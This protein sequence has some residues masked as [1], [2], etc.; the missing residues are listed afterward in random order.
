MTDP[1]SPILADLHAAL[2]GVERDFGTAE[3]ARHVERLTLTAAIV[4]EALRTV[5]CRTLLVGGGAIEFYA[6]D[7]YLTRDVDL[8]VE[9]PS[10]APVRERLATI[11]DALG[12]AKLSGRHWERNGLLVEVPGHRIEDP[13]VEV[14]VGSYRL[15]VVR[16]EVVL[17]GRVV[18]FDQT[19]HTGHAAQAVL[20][21]RAAPEAL[22]RTLLRQLVRQERAERAFAAIEEL[23]S[24]G[25]VVTDAVL[26]DL[27]ERLRARGRQPPRN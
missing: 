16:L 20:L 17:V 19:G 13:F 25:I 9:D 5:G 8:V 27:H 15:N 10:G 1:A 12:F 26:R 11:F 6:P 22:D 14:A 2:D 21:L 24:S 3:D 4:S 7:A 18:E 23:A